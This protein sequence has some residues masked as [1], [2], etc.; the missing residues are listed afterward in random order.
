MRLRRGVTVEGE[1]FGPDGKPATRGHVV[2]EPLPKASNERPW[3]Y[4]DLDGKSNAF[5][6]RGLEVGRYRI[7]LQ[8]TGRGH[9]A[10][11]AVE[12]EA[13]ARGVRLVATPG[14]ALRGVV[15]GEGVGGFHV[16]WV[17]PGGEHDLD[18]IAETGAFEIASVKDE[19]GELLVRKEKDERYAWV[20]DVRPSAG[21]VRIPLVKGERVEGRVALPEGGAGKTVYA[22]LEMGSWLA[23][24]TVAPDGSFSFTGL[25]PGD[26]ALHL[27]TFPAGQEWRAVERVAA[28]TRDLM[29]PFDP[30]PR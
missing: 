18:G 28:G 1:A 11:D 3:R 13:P 15:E 12:V 5:V 8:N 6:L 10:S 4:T 24:S 23:N 16:R 2:A 19:P 21:T 20:K 14:V 26:Y 30:P 27:G 25:P 29:V 7:R 22:R 9:A 17:S